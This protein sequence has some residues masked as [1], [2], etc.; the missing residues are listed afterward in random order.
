MTDASQAGKPQKIWI[1]F[2]DRGIGIRSQEE[3]KRRLVERRRSLPPRCL[4]RRSKVRTEKNLV[5]SSDLPVFPRYKEKVRSRVKKIRT[6]SRWLNAVSAEASPTEI[7]S[8]AEL[9]FVKKIDLVLCFRR[10]ESVSPPEKAAASRPDQIMPDYGPSFPQLDQINVLP[11]HQLGYSGKGVLVCLLDTG[12]HKTHEVFSGANL[13]AEWDFVNSDGDVQQ[14]PFDPEDYSDSHGTGTWSI[15]GGYKPGSLIGPAYG[16]DFLL[17]KTETTRFEQPIEEDYWVAGLEWAESLGAEVVSSSLGYTD[18]YTY[19]EMNGE[20]AVTTVAA[21]R[22]VSLGVVVV[23]AVGNERGSSWG[24][25]IAPADGFDVVAVGAVDSSGR[26]ASFSSPGP[27]FD[28]RIKPEVCALGVDDWLA[29]NQGDSSYQQGSGTSFATP[30]VAGVAAL[31]LEI[32]RDWTPAHV[33]SALLQTASRA[34]NP[35]ND[36]GYGIVDATS[37]AGLNLALPVLSSFTVDDDSTGKSLG[38]GNGRVEPGEVIEIS[39]SLGNQGRIP[40]FSLTARLSSTHPDVVILEPAVTFP[41]LLPST[42]QSSVKPFVVRI[43]YAFL[44]HH[45]IFR[46]K[47]QGSNSLTLYETL[48]VSI[49]R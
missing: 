6:T 12:F 48:R 37:A 35:D 28:G 27:T 7:L 18:W 17:A 34:Q 30:L 46:L 47:V 21:N 1:Y 26:I 31:L 41:P 39:V 24:H 9:D 45:L 11:L 4:W 29:S 25:I 49:S 10:D 15:L 38:N 3:L 22:A 23:N 44:G 19:E 8:L 43:P 16:A 14:D 5:D 13:I 33:R 20:V 36:Y 2:S 32:H 40:A 42:L